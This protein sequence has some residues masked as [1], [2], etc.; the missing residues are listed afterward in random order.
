[1]KKQNKVRL[2][3][4]G[5]LL[6]ALIAIIV[7]I[8]INYGY[9]AMITA[10]IMFGNIALGVAVATIFTVVLLILVSLVWSAATG[11]W[12]YMLIDFLTDMGRWLHIRK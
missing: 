12:H 7:T 4:L 5:I 9:S 6:A 1:M 3:S 11:E 10:L 8:G 2:I